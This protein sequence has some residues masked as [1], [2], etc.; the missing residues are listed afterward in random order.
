M[1]GRIRLIALDLDGT[2]LGSDRQVH[3]RSAQ[4]LAAAQRAGVGICLASGRALATMTPFAESLDVRGPIVSCNGAYALAEDGSEIHHIELPEAVKNVVLDYAVAR[5]V[6]VNSYSRREV[7]FSSEGEWSDLYRRR[8]GLRECRLADVAEMR[9]VPA[10]KVLLIDHP[11]GIVEHAR[12][13]AELIPPRHATA[14]TSEA[15]YLEFLPPGV[16]KGY[17]LAAVAGYL[18]LDAGQV[19]AIGDYWNDLEMVAWAGFGGA[20]ANAVQGVREAADLVVASNDAGGAGE[21]IEA[22]LELA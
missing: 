6:H 5:G 22:A 15:D 13:L 21:F 19:A 17:G 9:R 1:P 3:P 12:H 11:E 18:G 8:T 2:L 10:T 7:L 16:N 14:V 20:V 4:A